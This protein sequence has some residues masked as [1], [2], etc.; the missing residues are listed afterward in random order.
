MQ[1]LG[2][3]CHADA[4]RA[5]P[6]LLHQRVAHPHA[7]EPNSLRG[8]VLAGRQ[9]VATGHALPLRRHRVQL[10]SFY[11]I[12]TTVFFWQM[13]NGWN[14]KKSHLSN[15]SFEIKYANLII[16]LTGTLANIYF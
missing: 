12:S 2:G 5:H 6:A 14:Y 13:A 10:V 1:S 15:Q 11:S 16:L 8:P 3:H 7:D 4:A 9:E